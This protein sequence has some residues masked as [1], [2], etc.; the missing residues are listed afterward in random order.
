MVGIDAHAIA[1]SAPPTFGQGREALT[2]KGTSQQSFK[3]D[4]GVIS[5]MMG[6][7]RS[8]HLGQ[9]CDGHGGRW[10]ASSQA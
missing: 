2:K 4:E 5:V 8:R 9:M 1:R 3:G 6:K 10:W 7:D